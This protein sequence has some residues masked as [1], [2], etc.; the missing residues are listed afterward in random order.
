MNFLNAKHAFRKR[1]TSTVV[2]RRS[3]HK[4]LHKLPAHINSQQAVARW[5]L[6]RPASHLVQVGS[7]SEFPKT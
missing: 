1:L 7:C 2:L 5:P 4:E 6:H 3:N